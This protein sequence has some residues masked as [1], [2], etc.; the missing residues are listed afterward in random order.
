MGELFQD[1]REKHRRHLLLYL[2]VCDEESGQT[3]GR[4]GD[5]TAEGLLVLSPGPLPLDYERT[6]RVKFPAVRHFG[7]PDLVARVLPCWARPD[8]NPELFGTG[9]R[10]VEPD[11]KV[12]QQVRYLVERLGFAD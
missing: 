2:D 4:L 1:R 12:L 5:V 10:F 11:E 8:V 3:L 6:V 9:F 7:G